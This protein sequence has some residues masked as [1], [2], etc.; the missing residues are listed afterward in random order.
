[1]RTIAIVNQKGGSAKTATTVSVAGALADRSLKTLVIDLDGQCHASRWLGADPE[2]S[3]DL[4][5]TIMDAPAELP[6]LVSP[7]AFGGID[8]ISGSKLMTNADRLSA[9]RFGVEMNFRDALAALPRDRWDFVL[10]DCPPNLG[11]ASLWALIGCDEV[12]VPVETQ[13]TS[14]LDGVADLFETL[15]FVRRR[16]PPGPALTGVLA[17]RVDRRLTLC[18]DI[19]DGLRE[20]LGTE[21]FSVEVRNNTHIGQAEAARQPITQYAARSHGAEDYQQVTDELL[22]RGRRVAA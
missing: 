22:S 5:S 1:M 10:V 15:E 21:V 16:Y 14:A 8:I 18:T 13:G 11:V 17:C 9:G 4:T 2:E 6:S 7:S 19:V 12:V 3:A 20:N